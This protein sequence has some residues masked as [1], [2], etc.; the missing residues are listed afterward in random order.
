MS[1]ARVLVCAILVAAAC[2]REPEPKQYELSG[3]IL[4]LAPER[5][6]VTIKHGDIK[7]FMPGMT[8]TFTVKDQALLSGKQPGDLVTATLVVGEVNAHLSSVTKTGYR[9]LDEAPPAESTSSLREGDTVADARLVDQSGT[10]RTLAALRG[11]RLAVTF[12]YTR[13]PF[14]EFC[15]LMDRHFARVQSSIQS[16]PD[17]ADVRLLTVTLDPAFDTPPV[18]QAHARQLKAD[19]AIWSFLTGPPAEVT[20]FATQFGIQNESDPQDSSQI[21]HS[22]RT[23]IIGPDGRLL[24]NY[25][26]NDWT[27]T[28]LLAD[29]TAA[30]APTD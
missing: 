20:S 13:C 10:P 30:P 18:L 19:P 25:P 24:K 14:P 3:Q 8:M 26:G 16:R 7:G 2:S 28:E 27:P 22:L 1:R 4:T 21:I 29:L 9:A 5:R 12:I 6:E 11:H 23:A 15:P 17:L